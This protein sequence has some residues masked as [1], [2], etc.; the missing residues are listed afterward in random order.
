MPVLPDQFLPLQAGDSR[1]I[2]KIRKRL[3]NLRE[4]ILAGD[5]ESALEE[6]DHMIAEVFI[7]A[8][9]VFSVLGK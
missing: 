4:D 9:I 3:V 8:T 6:V 7:Y 5:C 1:K 2:A